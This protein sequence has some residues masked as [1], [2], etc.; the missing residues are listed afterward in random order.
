MIKAIVF[1]WGGVLAPSDREIAAI[2]LA[3]NY[4]LNKQE[5]KKWFVVVEEAYSAAKTSSRF[6]SKVSKKFKISKKELIEAFN[7]DPPDKDFKLAK[8]LSKKYKVYLL[9]N[10][11]SFR[12]EYIRKNFDLSFF[13]KIFFSCEIELKKPDKV[14]FEYLLK[15]IKLDAKDC[16]FIDDEKI[17][18][19]TAKKM[20]FQ[21]I[22]FTGHGAL[23]K[24]LKSLKI[25]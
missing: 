23:E 13:D 16:L 10:Q 17:N 20:G 24:G 11:L 18:I 25:L 5:F 9:S 8:K 15:K 22:L 12:S 6:L 21:T 3:K 7:A 2:R 1:D 14:I 19:A 4:P